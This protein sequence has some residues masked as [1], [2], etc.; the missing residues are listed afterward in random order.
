MIREKLVEEI[1]EYC[2]LNGIEDVERF[3]NKIINK[4]FTLEKFGELKSKAKTEEEKAEEIGDDYNPT[5]EKTEEQ[6]E[7]V[8]QQEVVEEVPKPVKKVRVS[9]HAKKLIEKYNLDRELIEGTGKGGGITKKDVEK[10]LEENGIQK[11]VGNVVI[12]ETIREIKSK[13]IYD[14]DDIA[15]YGSNLL[16][17]NRET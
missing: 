1:K 8:V 3:I 16:D 6:V 15:Q 7:E 9:P 2:Q 4:G 11:E 14:E 17:K 13:D 10:Y 12:R 5:E